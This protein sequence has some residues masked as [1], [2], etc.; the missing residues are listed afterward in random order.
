MRGARQAGV[1]PGTQHTPFTYPLRAAAGV[2]EVGQPE[3]VSQFV[4]RDT[5]GHNLGQCLAV[6]ATD[7]R[8]DQIGIDGHESAAGRGIVG[9]VRTTNLI[10]GELVRPD[11]GPPTL[12]PLYRLHELDD[13][14]HPVVVTR[15][16]DIVYAVVIELPEVH[17][18]IDGGNGVPKRAAEPI[19]ACRA[20]EWVA[21][22][23]A[24]RQIKGRGVGHRGPAECLPVDGQL[25]V[26][27]LFVE[28]ANRI[29]PARKRHRA[30]ENGVV[31]TGRREQRYLGVTERKEDGRDVK[32]SGQRARPVHGGLADLGVQRIEARRGSHPSAHGGHAPR[33][34][35]PHSV[36]SE[37]E[38]DTIARN[39][40]L[41][42]HYLGRGRLRHPDGERHYR[43]GH[44][45]P[46]RGHSAQWFYGVC[47]RRRRTT[48][49]IRGI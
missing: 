35:S 30:I 15:V 6:R 19:A 25:I 44:R 31:V 32:R 13:V 34:G 49:R 33:L 11:P 42:P 47:H 16:G 23:T 38:S 41:H 27:N 10:E 46:R 48:Q 45:S 43:Q 8:N 5:D 3:S 14:H 21:R 36:G 22:S 40:T 1:D 4:R 24:C 28:R 2:V 12:T 9:G 17:R 39:N 29:R 20:V 7:P 37:I 18:A 26:G